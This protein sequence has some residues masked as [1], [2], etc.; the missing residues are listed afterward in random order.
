MAILDTIFRVLLSQLLFRPGAAKRPS[1]AGR[2]RLETDRRLYAAS[3]NRWGVE[4]PQP[5]T[6][7]FLDLDPADGGEEAPTAA[8]PAAAR[9]RRFDLPPATAMPAPS[10]LLACGAVDRQTRLFSDRRR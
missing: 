3:P 10:G 1:S 8:S 6:C 7:S 5:A 2:D 9:G 4:A